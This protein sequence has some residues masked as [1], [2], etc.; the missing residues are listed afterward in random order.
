MFRFEHVEYLYALLLIPVL[1][2]FFALMRRR[3][4]LALE[5]FG[6]LALTERLMP[7][8]SKIKHQSKFIM[9]MMA[10]ALLIIGVANPQ[11]GTRKEKVKHKSADVFIAL[12]ISQSMLAEDIRPNRLDRA[13]SFVLDLLDQLKGERIGLILFAGNAYLQMPL[14]SDYTAAALFVKSANPDQAP[15][16]GTA[17]GEAIAMAQKSFGTDGKHHK[18][19]IIVTD[20]ENF[21][22][23]AMSNAE[24]A[25]KEGMVIFT[26]G[27]GTPEGGFIPIRFVG[28]D[29]FKRDD[30][31]NPVRTKL[32]EAIMQNLA[33]TSEGAYFNLNNSAGITDVLQ[34]RVSMLDKKEFEQRLFNEYES[35]FQYFLFAAMVIIVLEFMIPYRKSSWLEDRDIFKV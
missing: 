35:Y 29:D 2:L 5:R 9:L 26:V 3:R 25:G 4:R 18:A 12:D 16:Q 6:D 34:N 32:N 13:K 10:F 28:Q 11:W 22:D 23:D 33:K 14:T 30:S 17:I 1:T 8:V 19:L 15:T 21:D 31:G 24:A 20:G 7:R 27:V